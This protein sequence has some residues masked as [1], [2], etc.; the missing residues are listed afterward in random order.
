MDNKLVELIYQNGEHSFTYRTCKTED[1]SQDISGDFTAYEEE[2]SLDVGE[3]SV[4]AKGSKV[5]YSL[6]VW[7][8][9]GCSYSIRTSSEFTKE[10][11]V[12]IIESIA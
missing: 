1:T 10:D 2:T 7:E 12:K 8:K 5:G 6:A 9:D 4:T 11:L 3:I